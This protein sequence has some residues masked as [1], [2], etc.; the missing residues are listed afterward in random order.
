[1]DQIGDAQI[2]HRNRQR[3]YHHHR[4]KSSFVVH[5]PTLLSPPLN[6]RHK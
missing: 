2:Q 3:H 1:M 6:N 5:I 4:K